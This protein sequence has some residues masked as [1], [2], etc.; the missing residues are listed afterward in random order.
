M[1]R[2][3][4]LHMLNWALY[5]VALLL[6]YHLLIKVAFIELSWIALLLILPLLGVIYF[7]I[8]PEERRQVIVF[9]LG[10]LMLDRAFT[11][12]DFNSIVTV[13]TG[14]AV[15]A[16]V[17]A[18]LAKW[19]GRLTWRAV[20]MLAAVAVLFNAGI[21]RDSL[22]V[23]NH[24]SIQW[25]SE[26]LY[27]GNWVD[28]F[29]IT[30]HDVD[31]DGKQEIIT[32]GNADELPLEPEVN[33]PQSEAERKALADKLLPL[34]PEPI[35]LYVMTW[36]D[37]R[38]V[39]IPNEQI[40]AD[41]MAQI[42]EKLPADFPGFPYYTMKNG[43]LV[44]N[45]QRQ[46][47]AEGMLM[48]G[49][50]PYRAFL[51]DMQNIDEMLTQNKGKMDSRQSF[52]E[53]SPYS[54]LSI[55]GGLLT[56]SYNGKPFAIESKATKLL[57]SMKL[58]DGREGLL[59]LG[60]HLSVLA[61]KPDG[62]ATEAYTLTRKQVPLATAKFIL[63]DIDKDNTDEML[64]A[65]T[66]SYI[67]KPKPDGTWDILWASQE[68]DKAFSFS[69]YAS[70]GGNREPEIIAQAKSWVSTTYQQRYLSGFRY[71]PEGLEQ[72]WKVYLP[73]M[74]VQVG[75]IDGDKEN[76]IVATIY[77]KHRLLVLKPHHIPVLPLVIA[78][79]V[80]LLGYGVVR[81]FRHA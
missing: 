79:F 15:A 46:S 53:G 63:A 44:P 54:N 20:S 32:Y 56:G 17:I 45:V 64:V 57:G 74:N 59:V 48:A 33:E 28:Y 27:H 31:Q 26:K 21:N 42:Q 61:V 37:G 30:L 65:S 9:S 34:K 25:E 23:W 22:A 29:P 11:R 24:F 50:A 35:S 52:G 6:I 3:G 72:T 12:L 2:N 81:R 41:T 60:E 69:N 38:L 78:L 16:L 70:V 18:L 68:G 8:R 76:E 7:L 55:E 4:F 36:K 62:T 40:S 77:D 19:Y 47:F 75:D 71:T 67:L 14:G 51:L 13:L 80:G 49:T 1:R 43:K 5:G 10:L 58:P 73:L 66:P 39:R